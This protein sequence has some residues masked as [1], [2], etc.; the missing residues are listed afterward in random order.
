M[1]NI[2]QPLLVALATALFAGPAAGDDACSAKALAAARAR[3]D[4]LY[5][6]KR[7]PEAFD[8]LQKT[9]DRCWSSLGNEDRGRLA[10]DLGLAAFRAGKPDE[11]LKILASAPTDLTADSKVAKSIAFNR[12]LCSDRSPTPAT[13][14]TATPQVTGLCGQKDKLVRIERKKSDKPDADV[15]YLLWDSGSTT[16]EELNLSESVDLNGDGIAELVF[17]A[18]TQVAPDARYLRW[19]VDCGSGFFYELFSE[20]AADYEVDKITANGWQL[21][22]FYNNMSPDRPSSTIVS[23]TTYRFDGSGYVAV[24]S[25]KIKRRIF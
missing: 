8:E 20:Y 14:A 22:Q 5:R 25:K 18:P 15:T 4:G 1:R 10:S 24:K 13:T 17:S 12:D 9:K 7:Y 2:R 21:V 3:F 19:Y 23:K 16:P 11:C 6:A